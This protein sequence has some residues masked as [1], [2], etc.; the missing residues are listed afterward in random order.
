MGC[1]GELIQNQRKKKKK[2]L[3]YVYNKQNE[4]RLNK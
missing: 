4:M 3:V 1:G 2:E